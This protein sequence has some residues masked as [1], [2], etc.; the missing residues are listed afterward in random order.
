MERDVI[1]F[2]GERELWLDFVHAVRKN[3]EQVWGVLA[4]VLKEYTKKSRK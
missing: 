2:R 4:P 3:R 1:S